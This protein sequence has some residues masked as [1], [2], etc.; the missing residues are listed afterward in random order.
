MKI[1]P[2]IKDSRDRESHTLFF[3]AVSWF[4][5][6]FKFVVAGL[7]IQGYQFPDMSAINFG[8]ASAGILAIW[9]GREW[10]NKTIEAKS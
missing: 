2:T 1:L 10:T 3:V 5:I 6:L 7:T 9:L 8:L 4:A